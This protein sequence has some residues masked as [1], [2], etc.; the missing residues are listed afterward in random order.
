LPANFAS[1]AGG[2][3]CGFN[4]EQVS[5]RPLAPTRAQSFKAVAWPAKCI[6]EFVGKRGVDQCH[7][8]LQR[9]VA[10]QHV[11]QL[12]GC[13]TGRDRRKSDANLEQSAAKIGNVFDLAQDF[14][15]HERI[16]DGWNG[17]FDALLDGNAVGARCDGFGVTANVIQG[18]NSGDGHAG[19]YRASGWRATM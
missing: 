7:I 12:A 15:Q 19:E 13:E 2:E 3:P 10:E 17:H 8:V 1:T 16:I 5:A 11:E 4:A 6:N 18:L 9:R 14:V